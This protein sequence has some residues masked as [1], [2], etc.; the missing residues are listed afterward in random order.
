MSK[1]KSSPI[2]KGPNHVSTAS[3]I[4][5]ASKLLAN[6]YF[7]P[8]SPATAKICPCKFYQDYHREGHKIGLIPGGHIKCSDL[9]GRLQR[10]KK[11]CPPANNCANCKFR[12]PIKPKL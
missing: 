11:F 9:H 6:P 3:Q 8:A 2:D 7:T 4:L 12:G 5:L 10:K 1:P